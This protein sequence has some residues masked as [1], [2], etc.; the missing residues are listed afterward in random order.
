MAADDEYEILVVGA[1]VVGLATAL[2]TAEAGVRTAVLTAEPVGGGST[3]RSAGAVSQLHGLMYTRLHGE[4]AAKNAAAYASANRAGFEFLEQAVERLGV[5]SQRRDALLVAER[6]ADTARIDDEHLAAV[7]AG[8]GVEKL[9]GIDLPFRAY[10]GIVLRDQFVVDPAELTAALAA[11][12]RVAGGVVIEG[13][14]VT[15]VTVAPG[16][17]RLVRVVATDGERRAA[18]VVLATGTPIL[19]RGLYA[20]KTQ[21]IR[22]LAASDRSLAAPSAIVGTVGA[23]T[24]TLVPGASGVTLLGEE[25][26][27]G[28]GGPES[29][30]AAALTRWGSEHLPGFAPDRVWSG[31][32][33]RPH[34]PIAFVGTLPRAFGRITFASGFAGWGLTHGAAAAIR[35]SDDLLERPQ[36]AWAR[37]IGRRVTRPGSTG[38]GVAANAAAA[39]RL[40]MPPR[41]VAADRRLLTDGHGMVHRKGDQ[42]AATS[43]VDGVVRTI[44]AHCPRLGGVLAWNDLEQSWDCP[45]CGS[46]FAPDGGVIEGGAR[47]GPAL[48]RLNPLEWSAAPRPGAPPEA[49]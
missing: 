26:A 30:R 28:V 24:H 45:V 20:V 14:R 39:T 34:N 16:A 31:Q 10:G 47:G 40:L 37:T 41:P 11:A 27:T 1:G 4:T 8:L 29:R 2:M 6:P 46:R 32:D 17:K 43:R 5:A 42:L 7:R 12:I 36:A 3:G 13:A 23:Q 35:I 19:D 9:R 21:P 48:L 38:R 18:K 44:D 15:D 22:L 25:H 49:R 33:Y